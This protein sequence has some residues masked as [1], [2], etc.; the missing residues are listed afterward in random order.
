MKHDSIL[1]L[2]VGNVLLG[3]EGVGVHAVRA[4]EAGGLPPGVTAVDGG[5]GGFHLL[6]YLSDYRE[7]VFIDATLDGRPAGTIS[8]LHPRFA[9]D[10]P[11]AL[12]AHDGGLRDLVESAALLGQLPTM[13][14]IAVSVETLQPFSTELSP[15]LRASIPAVLSCLGRVLS[16]HVDAAQASS[17]RRGAAK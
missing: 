17:M 1:V 7:V 16:E 15:E 4:F 11:R 14:L 13:T 10:F 2:G 9:S 6:S 3:D 12:S 5:T 8:V